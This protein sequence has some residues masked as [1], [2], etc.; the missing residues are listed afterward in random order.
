MILDREA[1]GA[2]LLQAAMLL[3]ENTQ[4]LSDIDSR[5]GDGD[6]GDH[7]G[8]DRQAHPGAGPPVG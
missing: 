3:E 2:M 4:Y 8:K 1:L 6:H 7:H 5:F